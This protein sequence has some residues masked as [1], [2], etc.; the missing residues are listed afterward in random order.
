LRA[1]GCSFRATLIAKN[2]RPQP[3]PG[4]VRS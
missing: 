1:Y 4:P 2:K 3:K